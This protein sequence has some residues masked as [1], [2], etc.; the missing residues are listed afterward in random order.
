MKSKTR[1]FNNS[2]IRLCIIVTFLFVSIRAGAQTESMFTQYMFNETFINPA[3]VGSRENLSTTLVYRNQWFGI[4]GA[5]KTQAFS[6]HSPAKGNHLGLGMCI[7]NENIGVTQEFAVFG[8]FA[9]RILMHHS[10]L[11]FGLLGGFLNHVDRFSEVQTISQGDNQFAS[12][13]NKRFL[14]NAGFGIYFYKEK[15]YA[16]FSIPRMIQ[17]KI[18]P[19]KP[20]APVSNS[21]NI[22][23]WH[24]FF[25]TGY[26][27]DINRDLKFK[28]SLMVKAVQNSPVELDA[29]IN[30]LINKAI[31]LGAGYRTGDAVAAMIGFQINKQLR[32][33]YSYDYSITK[34]QKYNSGSHEITIG[35]EFL[36]NKARILSSRYF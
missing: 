14:P 8:N 11:S 29:D 2:L 16:G 25:M 32:F 36:T 31:W 3:Y 20:D 24:Y 26:V 6:I 35:Y 17:N 9:Y 34:L 23:N 22:K 27:F 28:P 19:S 1:H 21:S 30:F 13:I 33:N 7:S 15:Y 5:P 10:A 18:D 4:E 12:D